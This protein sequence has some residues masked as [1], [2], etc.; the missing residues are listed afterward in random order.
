VLVG[1]TCLLDA[2]EVAQEFGAGGV[3]EVVVVER[4]TEGFCFG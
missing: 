4:V 2:A 1:F 3:E